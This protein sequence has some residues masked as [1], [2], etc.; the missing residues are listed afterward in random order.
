MLRTIEG[1]GE[2]RD[3]GGSIVLAGRHRSLRRNKF[4]CF[5]HNG[6]CLRYTVLKKAI[7]RKHHE[8]GWKNMSKLRCQCRRCELDG[9]CAME[10]TKPQMC[11][12]MAELCVAFQADRR[13][14]LHDLFARSLSLSS[15]SC[16]ITCY[17]FITQNCRGY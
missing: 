10:R 7:S 1:V 8:A 17:L 14:S 5:R 2:K 15:S 13:A 11:G 16:F 9:C 3:G 12:D 6:A 4:L